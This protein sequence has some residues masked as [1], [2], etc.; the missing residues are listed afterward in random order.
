MNER[1]ISE[2][3]ERLSRKRAR[4]WPILAIIFISQQATFFMGPETGRSVDHVR[5]AA[6]MMLSVV[7]LLALATGG[8]WIYSREV[9]ERAN[10][11]VTRAHRDQSFR[12]A[13]FASMLG[14][15]ALYLVSYFEP[16]SGR[17]AL[18]LVMTI[19]IAA[20][21]LHLGVLERRAYRDA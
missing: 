8:G 21:L 10:D 14:C 7:L 11:E 4:M 6:W 18:H 15:I 13:F 16:V 19:G 17:E 1:T 2:Q 5:V 20:A 12:T 3:A 9:R